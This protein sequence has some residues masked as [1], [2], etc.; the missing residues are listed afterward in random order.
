MLSAATLLIA[1]AGVA[2]KVALSVVECLGVSD[3]ST[4]R[5]G[6]IGGPNFR[7]LPVQTLDLRHPISA[8]LLMIFALSMAKTGFWA[9]GPLIL[10]T[11]FGIDPLISGYILAGEALGV[12]RG[13]MMVSSAPISAAR[14]L[15]RTGCGT[16]RRR[17]RRIHRNG[18]NRI[19]GRHGGLRAVGRPWIWSL[20]ALDSCAA[21]CIFPTRTSASSRRRRPQ[22]CKGSASLWAL[23]QQGSPRTCPVSPMAFPSKLPGRRILGFRRF[24]PC[25]GR[26]CPWSL[27][28][29]DDRR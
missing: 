14:M 21:S 19:A 16:G 3:C 29:H 11:M 4:L 18:A 20:L 17:D 6:W 5:Q 1:S 28:V 15:I 10:K 12:E 24:H 25:C 2:Q 8:G 26:R 23:R 13:D 27:A 9:Y 7:M 22:R